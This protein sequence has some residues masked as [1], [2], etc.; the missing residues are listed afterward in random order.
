M[1]LTKKEVQKLLKNWKINAL[2]S[3]KKTREGIVNHNWIIKTPKEKYILRG[4]SKDRK[5]NE[6]LFELHFLTQLKKQKFPYKIPYPIKT[7]QNKFFIQYKN[8]YFWLYNFIEGKTSVKSDISKIKQVAKMISK[9]H[10]SSNRIKILHKKKWPEPFQ[11]KW[12]IKEMTKTK[13][14]ILNKKKKDKKD[15]YYLKNTDKII[16]ILLRLPKESTYKKFKK[17]PVHCDINGENIVI[18]KNKVTGLIDFDNARL[19]TPIRDITIFLQY[20]CR[21]TNV[22]HKL[23]F[24]KVKTFLKE[25]TPKL[26]KKE[27]ELIPQIA[28]S[29]FADAF[30][31]SYYILENDPKRKLN[32]N[33]MKKAHKSI[34]WYNNNQK[35]IINQTSNS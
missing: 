7:A 24:K 6:L 1:R 25:Y 3:Y 29:E 10:K 19:D 17:I 21:Q 13:K 33:S 22:K 14:Y 16:K 28:I 8:R 5:E 9:L 20:E 18:N 32:F 27:I 4:T 26:T 15:A 34:I 31:W 30:W 35:E 11:T 23:D 2:I 12:L